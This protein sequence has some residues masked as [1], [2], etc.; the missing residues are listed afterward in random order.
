M[1]IKKDDIPL[2]AAPLDE[3]WVEFRDQP[4]KA[5]V[6]VSSLTDLAIVEIASGETQ[7]PAMLT[8]PVTVTLGQKGLTEI[9]TLPL[10][11]GNLKHRYVRVKPTTGRIAAS[12][13]GPMTFRHYMHVL[14]S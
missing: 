7:D 8:A 4:M 11:A 1:H 14:I 3:L 2:V 9:Q 13:A 10:G 5:V 6:W 12:V